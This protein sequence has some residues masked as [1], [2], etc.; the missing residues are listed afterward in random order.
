MAADR[1]WEKELAKI[2]RRIGSM[3]DDQLLAANTASAAQAAPQAP[4]APQSLQR[5]GA[6]A[7]ATSVAQPA[8][9]ATRMGSLL[10]VGLAL[11]LAV[12]IVFWP[13]GTTCGWG[14]FGYLGGAALRV[15]AGLW[16]SVHTW[17]TRMGFAH[18]L[19]LL[20][21]LWGAGLGAREILPRIGY[22]AINPLDPPVW[23]CR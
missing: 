19:A 11:A 3:T 12:G 6:T 9:P 18:V 10:R 7:G 20:L 17:R 5:P 21:T 13:Y 1:D 8:R 15:L 23:L 14:L 4:Q 2:D 16:S 22:A